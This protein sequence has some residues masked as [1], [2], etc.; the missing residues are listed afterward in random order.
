MNYRYTDIPDFL[1]LEYR[2]IRYFLLRYTDISLDTETV[3]TLG[4]PRPPRPLCH[5]ILIIAASLFNKFFVKKILKFYASDR[6]VKGGV[7]GVQGEDGWI[8][9]KKYIKLFPPPPPIQKK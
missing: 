3:E 1:K 5:Q 8:F 9:S 6:Q 4:T 2:E 7:N